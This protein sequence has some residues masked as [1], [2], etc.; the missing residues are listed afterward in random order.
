MPAS[1]AAQSKSGPPAEGSGR[2]PSP[3]VPVVLQPPLSRGG[4]RSTNHP[5][6]IDIAAALAEAQELYRARNPKSLAQYQE[7]CAALPGGNTRSAIFVD[8]F[9]VT[10]TRGEGAHLWDLDGHEY[11]DFLSEFTAGL[12]GHSHPAIRRAIDAA[13]DSG[14]NLGAQGAAEARFARAIC[15]RFPSIERVRF[16]NSGTEA[17]LMAVAAARALTGRDKILVFPG[18]YHGGVFYFRG[19][20]SLV[21]APFEFLLAEYNDIEGTRALVAPHRDD[22]AAI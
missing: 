22:L 5:A 11:V 12:F 21:N 7:A 19:K 16:T 18:G 4:A 15:D 17:N 14:W 20:G 3:A 13:L 10:M 8:P 9:P 2:S 6:N 1:S